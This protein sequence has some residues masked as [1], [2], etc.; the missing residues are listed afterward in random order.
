MIYIVKDFEKTDSKTYETMFEA[1]PA[2][3]KQK[4]KK[5]RGTNDF[6]PTVV[7]YFVVKSL[8]GLED[9]ADFLYNENGKPFAEGKKHFSISHQENILAVAVA[10]V[11]VG[12]DI[13]KLIPYPNKIAQQIANEK[14]L[15]KIT[16][17]KNPSIE[18]TKLWTKKESY[19]KMLGLN[20][21][22]D[23]KTLL[24]GANDVSFNFKK[25][26]N[27]IVCECLKTK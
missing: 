13:Q 16:Q 23:L 8:I 15:E 27:Y 2:S 25:G 7:E 12:V 20:M 24:D 9:G 19:L 1:L 5:R 14:E 3:I 21:A 11:P 10:D 18:L 26:G 4:A 6:C 22:R 17:S